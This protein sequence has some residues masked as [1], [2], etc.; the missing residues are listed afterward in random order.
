MLS[1]LK[2]DRGKYCCSLPSIAYIEITN[3][4]NLH[5]KWCYRHDESMHKLGFGS[6]NIMQFKEIV[7]QVKGA[8]ILRLWGGG[9]PLLYRDLI[10]AIDYSAEFIPFIATTTN[11]TLL[12]EDMAHRLA[13]SK[14]SHLNV[15][16]DAADKQTFE[17]IRGCDFERVIYNVKY[18]RSIS[19]IPITILSV[20]SRINMESLADIPQLASDL[21]A[22]EILFQHLLESDG[23]RQHNLSPIV[24]QE[25]FN[26]FAYQVSE[27]AKRASIKTNILQLGVRKAKNDY[28]CSQPFEWTYINYLGYITPCCNWAD[29]NLSSVMKNGFQPAWNSK[30]MRSFRKLILAKDYPKHCKDWCNTV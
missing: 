6:M 1:K 26:D 14:L 12:D 4:C 9:E 19:N 30:Q 22:N 3:L 7:R 11:A 13:H 27:N 21:G 24:L 29:Y 23:S 2:R 17:Y 10:E 25:E 15:S 16:I 18:F 8:R 5:C 20:V 28:V